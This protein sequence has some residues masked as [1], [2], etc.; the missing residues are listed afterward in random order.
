MGPSPILSVSNTVTI[1]TMLNFDGG[2]N[3]HGYKTLYVNRRLG[4]SGDHVR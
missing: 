1:G 2:N 3:G 4:F